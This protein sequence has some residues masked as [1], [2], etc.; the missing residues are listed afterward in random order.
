MSTFLGLELVYRRGEECRIISGRGWRS[1]CWSFLELGD[2]RAMCHSEFVKGH[3]ITH[4]DVVA[5]FRS[6]CYASVAV[7]DSIQEKVIS[8]RVSGSVNRRTDSVGVPWA[9]GEQFVR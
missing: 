6:F 1:T 5:W 3:A 8:E 9:I 4:L 7:V 2:A